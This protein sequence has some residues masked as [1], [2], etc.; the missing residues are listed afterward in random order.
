MKTSSFAKLANSGSI[1][2]GQRQVRHRAAGIDSDLVRILAHHTDQEV[3]SIF[4]G[5]L[6]R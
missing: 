6:C 3:G 5:G 1:L 2:I 4:I